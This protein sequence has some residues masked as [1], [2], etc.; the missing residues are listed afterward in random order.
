MSPAKGMAPTSVSTPTLAAMRVNCHF[1][2]P[3]L[4]ASQTIQ[5]PMAAVAMSPTTGTRPIRLSRPTRR[6]VPGMTN[7]PSSIASIASIR[8]R[9]DAG[10]RPKPGMSRTMRS[11]WS[12]DSAMIVSLNP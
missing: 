10:S 3:R 6:L 12:C 2:M 7:S 11:N 5:A 4:R 8:R 1:D 9:T